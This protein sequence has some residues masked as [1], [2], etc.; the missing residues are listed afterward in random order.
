MIV[1]AIDTC[2]P[3]GGVTI[4]RDD[5]VLYSANHSSTEEYSSWLLPSVDRVLDMAGCRMPDVDAYGV[6][7]GP[8]SFTGVRIGLTTVKAW[9]EVYRKPIAAVS[10]LEAIAWQ[11]W[12]GTE[13]VATFADARRGQ[14][15]GAVYKRSESELERIGDEMV[16]PP[17]RF[18]Q[19]A[20]ELAAGERIAWA[21]TDAAPVFDT[22]EWK[23]RA[24]L[25]EGT[26]LVSGYLDIA[27]GRIARNAVVAGRTTDALRLDANY[28][29]RSDAEIFWKGA[30]NG[31]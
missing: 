5:E 27:I 1:L 23:E 14:V 20:S 24:R 2:D 28:V 25:K 13:Y 21:F 10:R 18:V 17:G 9:G 16:M 3:R 6:A 31:H 30:A 12:G 7:S 29:R 4:L 22:E 15:F 19:A 8:G 26:E 11:A